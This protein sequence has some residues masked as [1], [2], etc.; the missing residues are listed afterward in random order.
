MGPGHQYTEGVGSS[1]RQD[2]SVDDVNN[3]VARDDVG[4]DHVSVVHL[5]AHG[6]IDLDP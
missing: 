2:N 3:T 4:L 6:G 5:H 1:V